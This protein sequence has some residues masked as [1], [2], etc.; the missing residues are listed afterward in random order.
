MGDRWMPRIV[1][2]AL[3]T[4]GGFGLLGVAIP[5]MGPSGLRLALVAL[6]GGAAALL[7]GVVAASD[8]GD[9]ER[10]MGEKEAP[11]ARQATTSRGRR[12]RR[13]R[14]RMRTKRRILAPVR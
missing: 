7:V 12:P 10:R 3:G 8:T 1:W 13:P 4:L 9:E 2:L 14:A 5:D 11:R 6:G